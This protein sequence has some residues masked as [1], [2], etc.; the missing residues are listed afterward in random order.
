LEWLK[1]RALVGRGQEE[2]AIAVYGAALQAA[3]DSGERNLL[4]RIHTEYGQLLASAGSQQ[5]AEQELQAAKAQVVE[6]ADTLND[7]DLKRGFL[8]GA[9]A[10]MS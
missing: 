6:L 7:L 8:A 2:L 1:G 9:A 4:W 5:A 3:L 10:F